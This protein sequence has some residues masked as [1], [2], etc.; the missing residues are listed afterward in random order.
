METG[1]VG[2]GAKE[3][4]ERIQMSKL[5]FQNETKRKADFWSLPKRYNFQNSS[6]V[7]EMMCFSSCVRSLF[8]SMLLFSEV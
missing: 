6:S 8:R 1:N 3:N 2:S 7:V 4:E 5:L